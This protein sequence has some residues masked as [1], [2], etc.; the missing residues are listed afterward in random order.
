MLRGKNISLEMSETT[1]GRSQSTSLTL[2]TVFL[3][4]VT[5]TKTP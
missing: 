4:T 3:L 2:Q 5:T 1:Q